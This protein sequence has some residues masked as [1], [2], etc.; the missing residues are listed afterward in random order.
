[1]FGLIYDL[2]PICSYPHCGRRKRRITPSGDYFDCYEC[3]NS[4]QY[5]PITEEGILETIKREIR[6]QTVKGGWRELVNDPWK[7][8]P[9]SYSDLQEKIRYEKWKRRLRGHDDLP[10]LEPRSEY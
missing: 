7:N 5:V 6:Y 2:H 9:K 4:A 1:M 3:N 8:D 10:P